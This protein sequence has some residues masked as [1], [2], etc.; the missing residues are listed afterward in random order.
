MSIELPAFINQDR[1][2]MCGNHGKRESLALVKFAVPLEE[3]AMKDKTIPMF[4]LRHLCVPC[5]G[6]V[7][8]IA[9]AFMEASKTK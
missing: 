2:A 1:C 8:T 4:R 3:H 9:K 5:G 7:T 6:R